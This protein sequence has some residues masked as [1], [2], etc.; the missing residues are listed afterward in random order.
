MASLNGGLASQ[1][2]TYHAQPTKTFISAQIFNT[3]LLTYTTSINP[4]TFQPQGVLTPNA[5]AT[6][7][8]CPA[9]RVLHTNGRILVPGAN[10]GVN[11]PLIGVYDPISALNGFIDPTDPAFGNYDVS[12]PYQYDL[13]ISSVLATLGGQGAN[14][15]VGTDSGRLVGAAVANG[16]VQAGNNS[17]GEVV[18]YTTAVNTS[19]ITVSSSQ[20]IP[21]SRIFLTQTGT[22]A[23]ATQFSTLVGG[24]PPI[25][26][27]SSISTGFFNIFFPAPMFPSDFRAYNFVVM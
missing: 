3:K 27:V 14:L 8:N 10:P 18:F 4:T 24:V 9:N 15:R 16:G 19:T 22:A 17:I 5:N 20:I 21:T 7:A 23:T 13:G 1:V 2:K 6:A 25:P 26:T 11:V 12:M